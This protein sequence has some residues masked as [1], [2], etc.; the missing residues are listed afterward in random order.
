MAHMNVKS[1]LPRY[2]GVE[3]CRETWPDNTFPPISNPKFDD[4]RHIFWTAGDNDDLEKVFTELKTPT[5]VQKCIKFVFN[6]YKTLFYVSIIDSE[7]YFVPMNNHHYINPY[8]RYLNLDYKINL[9]KLQQMHPHTTY[10]KDKSKWQVTGFL[11]RFDYTPYKPTDPYE[12]YYYEMQQFFL[13]LAN[14][15]RDLKMP[16]HDFIIQYRDFQLIRE[17]NCDPMMHIVGSETKPLPEQPYPSHEFMEICPVL[18]FGGRQGYLDKPIITPDDVSYTL[19]LTVPPACKTFSLP[20]VVNWENRIPKAVFRGMATGAGLTPDTNPRMFLWK[21]ASTRPDLFDVGI[22]GI[23]KRF[24]KIITEKY[25]KQN[26][27]FD[28][29]TKKKVPIANKLTYSEQFNYKFSIYVEGNSAAYRLGSMLSS[30]SCILKVQSKFT[31]WIESY[32]IPWKH[33]VPVA[34][35]M[36]D[37]IEKTTWCLNNDAKA[38]EIGENALALFKEHFTEKALCAWFIDNILKN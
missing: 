10:E 3:Q 28:F 25:I 38:K 35:N 30:A 36:S 18:S 4:Y 19:G 34:E 13:S 24:K 12:F 8:A 23:P 27:P 29:S 6:R 37:L 14:S 7:I 16:R 31:M 15:I 11:V 32:M 5:N 26:N 2:T 33:Y 9:G 20:P 21:L 17:N 1:L 22:T